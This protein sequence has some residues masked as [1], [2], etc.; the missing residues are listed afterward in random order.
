LNVFSL[1]LDSCFYAQGNI[2]RARN[3]KGRVHPRNVWSKERPE[4][5]LTKDHW[6][7]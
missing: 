1:A 6:V 5:S 7:F 3:R 2:P 4:T